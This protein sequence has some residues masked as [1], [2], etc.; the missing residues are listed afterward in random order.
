MSERARETRA[1]VM[2]TVAVFFLMFDAWSRFCMW[3]VM[4]SGIR[5]GFLAPHLGFLRP[6]WV[7]CAPLLSHG[8]GTRYYNE[9]NQVT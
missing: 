6:T 9:E 7:S 4:D 8:A 5:L 1:A 2:W 3:L